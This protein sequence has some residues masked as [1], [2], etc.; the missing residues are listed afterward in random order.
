MWDLALAR[1]AQTA[2]TVMLWLK[3]HTTF[4]EHVAF[5]FCGRENYSMLSW[6]CSLRQMVLPKQTKAVAI[7]HF[8]L[9]FEAL[10][11]HGEAIMFT[12]AASLSDT[13]SSLITMTTAIHYHIHWSQKPLRRVLTPLTCVYMLCAGVSNVVTNKLC[14][15]LAF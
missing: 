12:V 10:K 15:V 11:Q 2:V 3:T 14:S 6:K 4:S 13:T 7:F 1:V 5:L 9:K 8:T